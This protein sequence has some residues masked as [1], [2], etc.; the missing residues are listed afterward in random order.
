VNWETLLNGDDTFA[1]TLLVIL[2]DQCGEDIINGDSGVWTAQTVRE[3]IRDIF[4]VQLNDS[5]LSKIM[6]ALSIIATDGMR[7]S[8]PSFL[9]AVHGLLGDGFDWSYAEPISVEDLAWCLTEASLLW[10]VSPDVLFEPQ[11]IAYVKT[12]LQREGIL[13]PPSVLRFAD[14]EAR[15]VFG[16][17]DEDVMANQ[18]DRTNSVQEYIDEQLQKLIMEVTSLNIGNVT[19]DVLVEQLKQ[20]L[21]EVAAK[22]KWY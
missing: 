4:S 15:R 10:P 14:P 11:I 5:A 1:T 20:E 12:M 16:S 21:Q 13:F 8:L 22:D 19:A 6:A 17:E 3:E 18:M 9:M 7:N 2:I